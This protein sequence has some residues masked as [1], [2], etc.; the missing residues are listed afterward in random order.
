MKLKYVVLMMLTFVIAFS[1]GYFVSIPNH[2]T[3]ELKLDDDMVTI[4]ELQ[5]EMMAIQNNC[6]PIIKT[7]VVH[8][9]IYPVATYC[10]C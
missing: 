2:I 5:K 7:K 4:T 8:D 6:T 10:D 9:C 3:F 1:L